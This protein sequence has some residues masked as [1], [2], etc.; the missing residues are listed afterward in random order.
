MKNLRTLF[1]FVLLSV[2]ANTYAQ[3]NDGDEEKGRFKKENIFMGTSL[4]LGLANHSFN[5]GLNPEIG[6][7]ITKW[8]D[9]GMSFNINYFSQNASEYSNIRFRN[10]N[11]G[12]GP[13]LRVWPLNFLHFQVQPEYNWISSN[14]K[15]V[16]NGQSGTYKYQTGSLLVGVGYGTHM[17]GS[18]YSYFTLMIDV[19]QNINSPYRDQYNDPVPI[20]RAGF[21]FYLKGKQR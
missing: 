18:H 10:F 7:S 11:F 9:G 8:L 19:L 17:I 2:A 21:G 4:N 5:V 3:Q 12:G 14:Q 20:V 1:C 6:Y 13:F 15:N 16:Q